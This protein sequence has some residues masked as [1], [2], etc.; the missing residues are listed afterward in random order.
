[1]CG[2]TLRLKSK[3]D[4]DS[5]IDSSAFQE[6]ILDDKIANQLLDV[7]R[8]KKAKDVE[9]LRV[10]RARQ[11]GKGNVQTQVERLELVLLNSAYGKYIPSRF[12]NSDM[13]IRT[14]LQLSIFNAAAI[15]LEDPAFKEAI[16]KPS[17][18][19]E[20]VDWLF[21]SKFGKAKSLMNPIMKRERS[22]PVL[23][24]RRDF[25]LDRLTAAELYE[26]H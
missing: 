1:M 21:D 26:K 13:M 10:A 9:Q 22:D 16:E 7:V 17:N 12:D 3:A 18:L 19:V 20:V 6:F 5:L 14:I 24:I 4:Y 15:L 25:R 2:V 23:S 11:E 8:A